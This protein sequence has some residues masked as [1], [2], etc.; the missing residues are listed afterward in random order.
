[1]NQKLH[2]SS[3]LPDQEYYMFPAQQAYLL[4]LT[5][6]TEGNVGDE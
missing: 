2:T 4:Q 1:M 6:M 5:E 3:S